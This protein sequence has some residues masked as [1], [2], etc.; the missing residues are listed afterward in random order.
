MSSNN[1]ETQGNN[2]DNEQPVV[3]A[4]DIALKAAHEQLRVASQNVAKLRQAA[5]DKAAADLAAHRAAE[6]K[7]LADQRAEAEAANQRAIDRKRKEEER[8]QAEIAARKAEDDRLAAEV[9]KREEEQHIAAAKAAEIKKVQDAARALEIEQQQLEQSLRQSTVVPVE[10]KPQTLENTPLGVIFGAK[11]T[12][13]T[14]PIRE[15]SSEEG[16]RI[17]RAEEARAEAQRIK[18][19]RERARHT[20]DM[21]EYS[22][23]QVAFPKHFHGERPGD[24][25]LVELLTACTYTEVINAIPLVV[26]AHKE[27]P[28][29]MAGI[30]QA[31]EVAVYAPVPAQPEPTPDPVQPDPEPTPVATENDAATILANIE[32]QHN[33]EAA[34]DSEASNVQA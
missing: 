8:A 28:M 22:A 27:R 29:S 3:S 1:S 14:E 26:A 31:I 18:G 34:A 33:A 12:S 10:E 32:A 6:E 20:V 2:M 24:A 7:R 4:E 30:L 5:L 21:N 25:G 23:L 9:S 11:P 19:P 13:T 15:I 16:S 17:Q